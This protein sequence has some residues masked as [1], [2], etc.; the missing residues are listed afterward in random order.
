MYESLLPHALFRYDR[1]QA[2][3]WLLDLLQ[4]YDAQQMWVSLSSLKET[5]TYLKM[6]PLSSSPIVLWTWKHQCDHQPSASRPQFPRACISSICLS[7]FCYSSLDAPSRITH[8]YWILKL[9][10]FSPWDCVFDV[11]KK[12]LGQ[13]RSTYA[14]R[15]VAQDG[16]AGSS[17]NLEFMLKNNRLQIYWPLLRQWQHSRVNLYNTA[18]RSYA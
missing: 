13:W 7:P 6:T 11:R 10:P 16:H 1:G 2:M 5:P 17:R 9:L 15:S 14:P 3:T 18:W 8:V 12:Y 4:A